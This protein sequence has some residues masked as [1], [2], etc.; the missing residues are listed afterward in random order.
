MEDIRPLD[1]DSVETPEDEDKVCSW[2]LVGYARLSKSERERLL[3][4]SRPPHARWGWCKLEVATKFQCEAKGASKPE[5][6][7]AG[8]ITGAAER[9]IR[10]SSPGLEWAN[11]LTA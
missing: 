8:H 10:C 2:S 5:Q 4:V 1:V 3:A 6:F 9:M 11:L 7:G